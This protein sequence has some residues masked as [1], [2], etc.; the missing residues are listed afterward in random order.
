VTD[1]ASL[2]RKFK[3]SFPVYA[4]NILR[5]IN[6]DSELVP[7]A[8]NRGQLYVHQRIE[9]QYG[10]RKKVRALNIKARQVGMSTY[11]EGRFFW[12]TTGRHNANAFVLAH[13]SESTSSIFKMV[14]NFYEN[15]PHPAFK[16]NL[17]SQ[18]ATGLVFDV[19]NSSYRVGTARSTNVGRGQTNHYVHCSEAAFYPQA[20]EIIAG[21]LQSVPKLESEV[22]VESTANGAGG[23]FYDQVMKATRGEGEWIV[24]FVPWFWMPEYAEPV[25]RYWE[26]TREEEKL[27]D[28]YKL[29]PEQL[30]FRRGKIDELGSLEFFLQEYPSNVDEAFRFSGHCFVEENHLATAEL[31]CYSP[32][33]VGDIHP[34]SGKREPRLGGNFKQFQPIVPSERY[35]IGGDVAEGLSHGDYSCATVLD[36]KGNQVASWHGHIDPVDYGDLLYALGMMFNKAWLIIE[37]NNHGLA[38]VRRLQDRSYPNLYHEK[39]VDNSYDD[40]LTRRVGFLTTSKTK[41]LII[42]GIRSLLRQSQAGLADKEYIGELRTYIV[43]EKGVTNAKEK[44]YD[45]RVM[46]WALAVFGL[47]SMPRTRRFLSGGKRF[48]P[49]CSKT[50]Y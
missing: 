8:L 11:T 21:L 22:I 31:E 38:T 3:A 43:D 9:R 4:K 39:E 35:C 28:I 42:D 7:F 1:L 27:A 34:K 15:V 19:L 16:P 12:R 30:N 5:I 47:N 48:I 46:S 24:N 26:P 2:A 36:S 18:T 13:L 23:W 44:C 14:A 40:K 49:G 10:A 33:F 37:R 45:D 50:G 29:T 20:E 6:K 17:K 41:P 32:I 25:H